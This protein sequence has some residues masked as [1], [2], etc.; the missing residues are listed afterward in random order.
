MQTRCERILEIRP[1]INAAGVTAVEQFQSDTLRPIVKFQEELLIECFMSYIKA[2]KINK[3]LTNDSEGIKFIA[4]TIQHDVAL[5]T[6][7]VYM[8]VGLFSK[9]EYLFFAENKKI[10]T[11]RMIDL[12]IIR[13]QSKIE[14]FAVEAKKNAS[15]G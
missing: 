8:I 9:E 4:E 6:S 3:L 7:L 12:I 14:V 10:L 1:E 15:K 2:H 13:L 5:K 11:K